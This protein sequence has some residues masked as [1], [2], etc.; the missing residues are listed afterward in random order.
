MIVPEFLHLIR[1]LDRMGHL[2][3]EGEVSAKDYNDLLLKANTC[4]PG[5]TVFYDSEV[6]RRV[7]A[8]S[9]RV[10]IDGEPYGRVADIIYMQD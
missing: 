6:E 2:E 4:A 9:E 7:V 5:W 3:C 10:V 8:P 1:E